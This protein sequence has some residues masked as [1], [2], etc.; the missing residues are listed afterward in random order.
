MIFRHAV[1]KPAIPVV[2]NRA[3]N[4]TLIPGEPLLHPHRI[5][6]RHFHALAEGFKFFVSRLLGQPV[7][8]TMERE[9]KIDLLLR[10]EP[11]IGIGADI[12]IEPGRS[13]LRR[14]DTKKEF[15]H[16]TLILPLNTGINPVA[17]VYLRDHPSPAHPP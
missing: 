6:P 10:R 1:K 4:K 2:I 11:E 12:A 5:L 7:K 3:L 8:T 17:R 16:V 13:R 9:E 14:A 15:F